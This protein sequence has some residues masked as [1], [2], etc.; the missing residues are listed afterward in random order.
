MK[1]ILKILAWIVAV[2]GWLILVGVGL[3]V[4]LLISFVVYQEIVTVGLLGWI[5]NATKVIVGVAVF[6][7]LIALWGAACEYVGWGE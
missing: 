3:S 7:G 4:V 1:K 6:L 5:W 2:T